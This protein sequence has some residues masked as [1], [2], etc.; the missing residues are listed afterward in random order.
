MSSTHQHADGTMTEIIRRAKLNGWDYHE[1]CYRETSVEGGWLAQSE[2]DRKQTE[3]TASM[4][5][6]EYEGQEPAPESRAIMPES[7]DK[8]FDASLGTF[9]GAP[10]EYIEIEPPYLG[11]P[12]KEIPPGRYATG[13]DWARKADW[14]V[15]PTLRTDVKPMRVVAFERMQRFPWPVM[16]ERFDKRVDRYPGGAAHDETGIGDVVRGYMRHNVIGNIMVGRARSD[17]LSNYISAVERGDIVSPVIDF[18]Q[19]EHRYASVDDVYGSG[20]LPDSISA[21][22][23]AYTAVR[24]GIFFG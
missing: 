12:D 7:V 18:M 23:N 2:V 6:T 4:W 22:A 24:S 21:M 15:I 20:H 11:D 9:R 19:A 5:Q 16:V 17:M 8:M 13:A 10:G 1:W 3:V 14:T